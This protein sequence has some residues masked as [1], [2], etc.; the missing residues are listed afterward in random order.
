V[1]E[2]MHAGDAWHG[3]VLHSPQITV[4]TKAINR[5]STGISFLALIHKM[6]YALLDHCLAR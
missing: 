6:G 5:R 2:K 4:L 1:N 3:F